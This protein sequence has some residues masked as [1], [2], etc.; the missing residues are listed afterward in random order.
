METSRTFLVILQDFRKKRQNFVDNPIE[1]KV[2]MND[3]SNCTEFH[4]YLL[5][6]QE[7]SMRI[8]LD[9]NCSH[10]DGVVNNIQFV[11]F[12]FVS[13]PYKVCVRRTTTCITLS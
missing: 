2:R 9:R 8:F 12:D 3:H 13:Y 7:L 1:M 11:L 6:N 4:N 10:T 5:N